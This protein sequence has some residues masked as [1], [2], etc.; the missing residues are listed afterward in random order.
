MAVTVVEEIGPSCP[1]HLFE[2]D[3]EDPRGE[4]CLKCKT[5]ITDDERTG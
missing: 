1:P 3:G 2:D 5:W 4:Y